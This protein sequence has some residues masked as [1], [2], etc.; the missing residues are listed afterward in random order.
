VLAALMGLAFKAVLY[1]TED[2]CDRLWHGRPER[3]RPA[4]GGVALGLLLLAIP[5]MYGA[6][7]PVMYKA[8][9]GQYVLWFLI[10]LAFGKIAACSLAIGGRRRAARRRGN[11]PP[12]LMH[13][14]GTVR[15]KGLQT[16]A[17]GCS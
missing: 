10:L 9:A 7:Y 2:L 16:S 14:P 17:Q 11:H 15:K 1:Q 4:A 5:Q 13:E 6:G 12:Y 8:T 3:A